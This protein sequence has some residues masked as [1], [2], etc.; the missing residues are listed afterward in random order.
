MIVWMAQ[1][2]KSSIFPKKP[3][4]IEVPT[5]Q[6][7]SLSGSGNPNRPE[8]SEEIA[9]LYTISYSLRMGLRAFGNE[10]FEYTVFPLEGVWT[11]LKK[12]TVPSTKKN[13][14]T[15]SWFANQ[16]QSRKHCFKNNS[17]PSREER[18][19]NLEAH[20]WT[21]WRRTVC[22]Q[23]IQVFWYWSGNI[24]ANEGA[25]KQEQLVIRPTMDT[26]QHREIYLSDPRKSHQINKPS[27]DGQ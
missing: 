17:W 20:L 6:F 21:L 26:F 10:P 2:R 27:C 7:I 23:C 8:F 11:S 12:Q 25:V 22:K 24:C 9:A 14:S 5:Y 19:P 18:H 15:K 3:T 16:N 1:T 13:W 4:V